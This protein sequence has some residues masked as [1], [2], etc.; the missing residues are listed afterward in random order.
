LGGKVAPPAPDV[1]AQLLSMINELQDGA[2]G[3]D[4]ISCTHSWNGTVLTVTSASGTSSA[5]LKG[6]KGDTGSKGDTGATGSPG[7]D[8]A[9]G[10]DG[11]DGYSPTVSVSKSGTKTTISITD[12]NGTK[13]ATINDGTNGTNGTNGKDG[14]A[15][16]TKEE[17][18]ANLPRETWTFTLANGSTVQKVVPKLS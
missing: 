12:K 6:A 17:V 9:A 11:S 18:I 7:K 4:G 2:D 15:G 1:Y 10:K 13:T 14:A 8:G 5:D 3:D 16:A